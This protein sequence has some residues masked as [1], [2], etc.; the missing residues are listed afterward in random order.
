MLRASF[1]HS[2]RTPER[3]PYRLYT[4]AI[5]VTSDARASAPANAVVREIKGAE[6]GILFDPV[7]VDE[8]TG[9]ITAPLL[10]QNLTGDS[11]YGPLTLRLDVDPNAGDRGK[12]GTSGFIP[13]GA[14]TGQFMLRIKPQTPTG[15]IGRLTATLIAT[16]ARK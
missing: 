7:S 6:L 4:S 10:V 11:L 1:T 14:T 13:A 9:I 12:F 16:T 15:S 3:E 8:S 5:R 2:G